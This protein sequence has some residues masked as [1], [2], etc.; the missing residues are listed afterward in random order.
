MGA[1][2]SPSMIDFVLKPSLETVPLYIS[3]LLVCVIIIGVALHWLC[4]CHMEYTTKNGLWGNLWEMVG[5]CWADKLE[6][7]IWTQTDCPQ[8]TFAPVQNI[9]TNFSKPLQNTNKNCRNIWNSR[10]AG[11]KSPLPLRPPIPLF[12]ENH[13]GIEEYK[14]YPGYLENRSIDISSCLRSGSVLEKR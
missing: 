9:N 4:Y 7:Y 12:S 2:Q 3:T 14:L 6:Q 10:A 13:M 1:N 5:Q 8:N 11:P